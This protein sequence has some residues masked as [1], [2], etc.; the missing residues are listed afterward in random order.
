M[1]IDVVVIGGGFAGLSAATALAEQGVGV[2][3]LEARPTLGGRATAFIDPGT[4]E[5]VDNGQHVLVGGYHE[6][7]AF[8]R[9]LNTAA[10]VYVQRDLHIDVIDREGRVSTLKCPPL[11]PPLHLLG[12]VIGWKGIGWRDRAALIHMRHVDDGPASETVRQWL[13]RHRQTPRLIELLWEPLAVAALNQSIDEASGAAFAGVVR[14]MFTNDRRDCA[15]ALPLKA[16]DEL[17]AIPAREY[18]ERAG[19]AVR[20]NAPARVTCNGRMTVRVRDERLQPTAVICATAWYALPAVFP[21]RPAPLETILRAAESTEASPIVTVNFW[22]DRPVTTHSFVGLPGRAMQW[23]FDKRALLG[24]AS[25]HL[26][27]VSSGATALVG[28]TNQELVDLALGELTVAFP[29]VAGAQL[30]RAVV[31]REKRATFSVAPGQPQRPHVETPLPEVFLAG[32][33]IDTGLPATIESAVVSGH[34]A[35]AAVSRFLQTID[36]RP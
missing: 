17:Y 11:P 2:L 9:R 19:G 15:L 35:A 6:T 32:D 4:S 30:R 10:D 7:F 29:A 20:V 31:V 23:V 28:Q 34:R 25:S 16:L 3:V 5:R 26:S 1:S 13:V 18:I 21:D 24:D 8:L 33:W 12:G 27:L 22:F 14:R 36:R